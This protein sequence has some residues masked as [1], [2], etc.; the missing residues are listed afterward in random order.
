M[1][2]QESKM[3]VID[4]VVE[5]Y[6]KASKVQEA[7]LCCPVDYNPE[8][9]KVIP[10]EVI[11]KD[12]G[13]GDPSQYVRS[14]ETV[15]DLGSGT[16][17]ICFIASQVV[18]HQGKVIGVDMNDDMLEVA[19]AA[20]TVVSDRIG[21]S[22]VEFKKGKIEDLK[23]DRTAVIQF[24]K[25]NPIDSDQSLQKF[26]TW[27]EQQ[28][29]EAPLIEDDSIDVVVSNCVLNLVS[30]EKKKVLFEE[31]F[32]VLKKG[33]RAVISDI[34]A[35]EKVPLKMRNDPELWSGCIS[36]AFEEAEFIKAFQDAGFYGMQILKRDTK[37]WQTVEGIE[38]RSVTVVAYKGKQGACFDHHEALV[39]RGPFS[40]VTDDDGHT[41][42]R[43]ERVAVCR[44]TYEIFK[45]EPYDSFFETIEP[46]NSV[47]E[48]E[49]KPF[50]CT[51]GW[52]KRTPEETKGKGYSKTTES[53][54]CC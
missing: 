46:L 49:A 44:K 14:G 9:L 35:D 40:S 16:G 1:K 7:A 54:S 28:L 52:I 24:L 32:R 20:Q 21:Y 36:G 47:S 12:Y 43:G 42:V 39:Y 25:K 38:F 22:N 26:E 53:S 50:P 18:G 2:N 29:R 31:I 19:R 30:D 6:S 34:V 4:S 13:C 23:E 3:N 15:L 10:Q 48:K 51:K 41:F 33:G 11:E 37:P 8:F 27:K 17:K 5:R 45:K